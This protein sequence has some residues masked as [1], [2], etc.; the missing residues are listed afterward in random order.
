ME[1]LL[2]QTNP[3]AF[4]GDHI[5]LLTT[6]VERKDVEHLDDMDFNVEQIH[7]PRTTS[8]VAS[9]LLHEED[10]IVTPPFSADPLDSE[11]QGAEDVEAEELETDMRATGAELP[12]DLERMRA[13]LEKAMLA[14]YG[15]DQR[16]T[17]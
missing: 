4:G 3:L 10:Y 8:F 14:W 12:H 15:G 5:F 13:G 7:T 11:S 2:T 17:A 16:C 9:D 1:G 6:V